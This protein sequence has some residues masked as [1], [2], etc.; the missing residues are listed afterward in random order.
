[1]GRYY[2][3][4]AL[5]ID[6]AGIHEKNH[7]VAMMG[8]IFSDAELVLACVDTVD[9][10][11][12]DLVRIL[13]KCSVG[14]LSSAAR[15]ITALVLYANREPQNKHATCRE[16]RAALKVLLQ[17]PFFH[18]AWIG[19]YGYQFGMPVDE[20]YW[21]GQSNTLIFSMDHLVQEILL[22]EKVLFCDKHARIWRDDVGDMLKWSKDVDIVMPFGRNGGYSTTG[23]NDENAYL[24]LAFTVF[25]SLNTTDCGMARTLGSSRRFIHAL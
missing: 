22:P 2:F 14:G 10:S 24:T 1:M 8:K 7:Q 9:R 15:A 5:C 3:I 6:Q 23:F 19:M 18:R 4:D 21:L 12:R 20:D 16:M 17:K 11:V 25:Q 13:D